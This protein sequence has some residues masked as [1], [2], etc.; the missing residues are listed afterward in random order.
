MDMLES[1]IEEVR[2]SLLDIAE[3]FLGC[4]GI[5]SRLVSFLFGF[6][7]LG[8]NVIQAVSC[9][10]NATI[11]KKPTT[12]R[13]IAFMFGAMRS[14]SPFR[15]AISVSKSFIRASGDS[16]YGTDQRR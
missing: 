12:Y 7:E 2:S 13:S 10:E 14:M 3:C 4:L 15:R 5:L 8:L 6:G 11:G 1:F 9:L 16:S